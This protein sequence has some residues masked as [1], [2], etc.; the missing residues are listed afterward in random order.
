MVFIEKYTLLLIL[1]SSLAFSQTKANSFFVPSDTLN[2]S[3]RNAVAITEAAI[4]GTT[5]LGLNQWW[6]AKY[7]R[8]SFHTINDNNEWLQMDKLGHTFSAYQMV[9]RAVSF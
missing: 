7:K 6:Y 5:W 3:R 8:S 2:I 9:N 4:A 1:A